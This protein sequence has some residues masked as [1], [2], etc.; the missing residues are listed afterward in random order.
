MAPSLVRDDRAGLARSALRARLAAGLACSLAGCSGV[1]SMLDVRGPAAAAIAELWWRLLAIGAG[2]YATLL[3]LLVMAIWH[4]R[5]DVAP[6]E[7]GPGDVRWV[8]VG[9]LVV[10]A[11]ILSAVFVFTLRT[12]RSLHDDGPAPVAIDVVGRRWWW[13][14]R[15]RGATP[16]DTITTAN[17]IHIPVGVR[18]RLRL[19]SADVIHSLWIP[20]LQG[21]MDLVPGRTTHLWLQADRAGTSRGQCAEFCGVQHTNMALAVV[22]ESPD[23][24]AAWR[25]RESAAA[26]LPADSVAAFGAQVFMRRDCAYCHTIRG[27]RAQ[28]QLGP[29]L[30]HVASRQTLAAGTLPNTPAHLA[31]WIA[32]P[33]RV[34][35]GSLMPAMP[36]SP[37]ELRG[38]VRYL[39][40]LR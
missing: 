5:K 31:A 26:T 22:A 27:T 33:Q 14:V 30:T 34:K 24:F 7:A 1:Q 3:I 21:K 35:P 28:G 40:A 38:L 32:E 20:N 25:A 11:V 6:R 12:M 29:D 17:E 18:V 23:A 37:D 2:V 13:E 10:P 15:Y 16:S 9:G 8:V 19:S 36:L 4:R 39:Q